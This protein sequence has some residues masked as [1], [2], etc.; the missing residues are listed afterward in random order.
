MGRRYFPTTI[1]K[2]KSCFCFSHLFSVLLTMKPSL[3]LKELKELREAWRR[4]SFKLTNEQQK[5]YDELI[6]L[7][8]KRVKE[9]LANNK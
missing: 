9:M 4:Q 8:R 2:C 5:R 6:E 7:R 1:I 3:V